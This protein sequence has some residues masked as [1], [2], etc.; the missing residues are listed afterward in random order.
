MTRNLALGGT[1]VGGLNQSIETGLSFEQAIAARTSAAAIWELLFAEDPV[2]LAIVRLRMAESQL[3]L[4]QLHGRPIEECEEALSKVSALSSVDDVPHAMGIVLSY[5][6]HLLSR[7]E[8]EAALAHLCGVRPIIEAE[9]RRKPNVAILDVWESSHRIMRRVTRA[10]QVDTELPSSP[11]EAAPADEGVLSRIVLHVHSDQIT[12]LIGALNAAMLANRVGQDEANFE[13]K[14]A[15]A[16]VESAVLHISA[17]VDSLSS[18]D[19]EGWNRCRR[20][21]LHLGFQALATPH[22]A[23][24]A[25]SPLAALSLHRIGTTLIVNT[26]ASPP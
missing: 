2:L 21:E 1:L 6:S 26:P 13:P 25:L 14:K 11:D 8:A 7:G 22:Q 15:C 23:L 19:R 17:I 9:A 10:L 12:G 4:C 3:R 24:L 18:A 16:N 20:R 5:C